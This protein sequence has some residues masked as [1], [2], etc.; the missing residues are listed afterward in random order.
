[1]SVSEI[2][3]NDAES[4][5]NLRSDIITSITGNGLKKIISLASVG[6]YYLCT[7]S[8]SLFKYYA[9]SDRSFA[10]YNFMISAFCALVKCV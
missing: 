5:R 10:L 6:K 4:K 2:Y 3:D 7:A 9:D 8:N 1:M